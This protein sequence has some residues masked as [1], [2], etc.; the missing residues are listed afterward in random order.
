M[1]RRKKQDKNKEVDLFEDRVV[2]INRVSKV[3]KGGRNIRFTALAVVGDKNGTIGFGTG[4]SL[5]IP[6]AINKAIQRARKNL[7]KVNVVNGT[8]PHEITGRFGAGKVFLKP[9][10]EGTGVIAG[11]PVRVICELAG[12]DNILSK[13]LGSKTPIN[14]VRATFD[15]LE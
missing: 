12:I 11:G 3:V 1:H 14:I 6:D 5:E 7:V 10:P 4:K 2:S 13:N 9:A 15:G 8:I